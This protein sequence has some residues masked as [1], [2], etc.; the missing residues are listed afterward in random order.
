[1]FLRKKRA[2]IKQNDLETAF[3]LKYSKFKEL[4]TCN[5]DILEIMADM[6]VKSKGYDQFTMA[7]I[8]SKISSIGVKTY[9]GIKN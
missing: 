7:Y 4:L 2:Q 5:N 8:R 3:K 1:M 6:D 9:K